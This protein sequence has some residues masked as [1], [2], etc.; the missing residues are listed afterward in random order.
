MKKTSTPVDGSQRLT[1][2]QI[3]ARFGGQHD[4][5]ETCPGCGSPVGL[6]DNNSDRKVLYC[7]NCVTAGAPRSGAV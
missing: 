7:G 1:A 2:P 3:E 6:R 4:R 5:S